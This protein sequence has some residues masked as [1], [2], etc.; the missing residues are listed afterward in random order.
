[1]SIEHILTEVFNRPL[2]VTPD[3]LHIILGVLGEKTGTTMQLD[4]SALTTGLGLDANGQAELS[5][6]RPANTPQEPQKRNIAILGL[7][8]TLTYRN[9]GNPN[10]GSGLLS[11]REL[12]NNLQRCL[13]DRDIDGIILDCNSY[14]G[15]AQ[16]C[17]RMAR[18][19]AQATT[20]KPIWAF[21][22][23]NC[24]SAAYYLAAATD[25]IILSDQDCGVGSIGCIAVFRD[26]SRRNEIEGD[27]YE[28]FAFGD[29][30]ADFSPHKPLS[31]KER[32]KL[33]TS[34]SRFGEQFVASVAEFRGVA[35]NQIR[36]TQAGVF[37]GQAAIEHHLADG[38]MSL[39]ETAAALAAEIEQRAQS[40]N[41]GTPMAGM[42][43]QERMEKLLAADDG[44][45]AIAACG[46]V[47]KSEMEKGC[48][49]RDEKAAVQEKLHH[50]KLQL[51]LIAG[52]SIDQALKIYEDE[53]LTLEETGAA[54]Q[55]MKAKSSQDQTVNSTVNPLKSGGKNPLIARAEAYA[56]THS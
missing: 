10:V 49:E 5:A 45:Q 43:T 40:I 29:E 34:V 54:I 39:D 20:Q 25:R 56:A 53:E 9:G 50:G 33:Q 42:T 19:I 52:L 44:P 23:M 16:G 51:A 21:V 15:S 7:L 22:D 36:D 38:I 14:G 47:P 31:D 26:Q 41:G 18:F 24:F 37:Y 27:T 28:V 48:Q 32:S 1:M 35:I 3:K 30:K 46:F 8:G 2:F 55:A 4:F 17:E 13:D 12:Q 6:V 11:Y